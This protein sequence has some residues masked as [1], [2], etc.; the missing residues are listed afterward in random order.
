MNAEKVEE[1]GRKSN[2][3]CEL[4][5]GVTAVQLSK[6]NRQEIF[7]LG[8]LEE[9]WKNIRRPRCEKFFYWPPP[10]TIRTIQ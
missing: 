10:A 7:S 1:I 9:Q 2:A 8:G 6:K 3:E 4:N 5:E